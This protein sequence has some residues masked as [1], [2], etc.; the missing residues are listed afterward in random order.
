MRT[1]VV[2]AAGEATRMPNK[3]LLPLVGGDIV[4]ESAIAFAKKHCDRVAVVTG[5]SP[6]LRVVLEHK[7]H[8]L[9]FVVQPLPL[10]VLDAISRASPLVSD[11]AL[12]V[13]GDNY[14]PD[15]FPVTGVTSRAST[16][17]VREPNQLD[18]YDSQIPQ[19]RRRD[20]LRR[21]KKGDWCFAGWM[22]LTRRQCETAGA[23]DDVVDF[24]NE[25]GVKPYE[26][27]ADVAWT[28]L[29]TPKTYEEYWT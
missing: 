26:V 12:V 6:L 25:E 29:G 21:G 10:G 4:V 7:G 27:R 9:E 17:L 19:W 8:D 2:L 14:Y 5:I 3:L 24:M 20:D 22:S 13:F 23:H 16:V 15:D 1:G 28:D 11:D 18:W